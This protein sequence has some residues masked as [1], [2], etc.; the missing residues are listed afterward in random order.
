MFPHTVGPAG[1]QIGE[2]TCH[3]HRDPCGG[4]ATSSL[5]QRRGQLV[6]AQPQ[7]ARQ[8]HR[9]L[10]LDPAAPPWRPSDARHR[11]PG[12]A[13]PTP[14]SP[15]LRAP[16]RSAEAPLEIRPMPGL[17][18]IPVLDLMGGEVVRARRADRASYRP[19]R[20]HLPPRAGPRMCWLAC[21]RCTPSAPLSRRS[22]RHSAPGRSA[23]A[24]PRASA[25][26]LGSTS[27]S[28]AGF[29]MTCD[30]RGF[31][32]AGLGHLVLGTESQRDTSLLERLGQNQAS[33]AL[34]ARLSRRSAARAAEMIQCRASGPGASSS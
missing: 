9:R 30:A 28:I 34:L 27:G 29:R 16:A 11:H 26:A 12:P 23:A 7:P 32:E 1:E 15:P 19:S 6:E 8:L 20:P 17:E 22:R 4:R 31:L 24:D 10:D 21:W 3:R 5:A 2:L 13:R 14:P 18:V 25:R 33:G